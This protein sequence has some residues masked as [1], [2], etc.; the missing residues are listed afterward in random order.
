MQ[1]RGLEAV[2]LHFLLFCSCE[3]VAKIKEGLVLGVLCGAETN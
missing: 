3:N 1:Q 2:Y